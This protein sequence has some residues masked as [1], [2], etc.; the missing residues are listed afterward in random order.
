ML[1]G[2]DVMLIPANCK[3]RP[4]NSSDDLLTRREIDD[5]HFLRNILGD[6]II[7]TDEMVFVDQSAAGKEYDQYQ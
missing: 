1:F 4:W 2:N 5:M 6:E 3:H 7:T